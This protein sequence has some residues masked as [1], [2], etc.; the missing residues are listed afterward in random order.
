M[1]FLYYLLRDTIDI[2]RMKGAYNG[3]FE[4]QLCK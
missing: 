4:K 2:L 3:G 1:P